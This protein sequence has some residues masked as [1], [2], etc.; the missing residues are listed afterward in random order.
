MRKTTKCTGC[1]IVM[2]MNGGSE[3][4]A[5]GDSAVPID[6]KPAIGI[7]RSLATMLIT[8]EGI[9]GSCNPKDCRPNKV[10]KVLNPHFSLMANVGGKLTVTNGSGPVSPPPKTYDVYSGQAII[11]TMSGVGGL[12]GYT[13][14]NP[15]DIPLVCGSSPATWRF[16]YDC[17]DPSLGNFNGQEF[18]LSV[19]CTSCQ[20]GD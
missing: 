9:D 2:S 19:R 6:I 15:Y 13:E 4:P 8:F 7:G 3:S 14:D 20:G 18:T 10:C 16:R 11:E 17:L 1:K 12:G 5:T